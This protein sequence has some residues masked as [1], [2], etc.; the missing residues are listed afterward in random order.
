MRWRA[1]GVADVFLKGSTMNL[2][3]DGLTRSE[4]QHW[5]SYSKSGRDI[6]EGTK[7]SSFKARSGGVAFSWTEVL[8]VSIVPLLNPTT[9]EPVDASGC[10]ICL[11]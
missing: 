5:G 8:S 10:H 6:Q 9:F 1:V 3:T 7:L 2:L 11:H 4:L